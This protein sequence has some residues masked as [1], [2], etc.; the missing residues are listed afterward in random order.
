M[1]IVAAIINCTM[2]RW[3]DGPL[4]VARFRA[5]VLGDEREEAMLDSVLSAGMA[6]RRMRVLSKWEASVASGTLGSE[7]HDPVSAGFLGGVER[8]VS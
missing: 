5:P 6:R 8:F 2:A 4:A 1:V 7:V 3:P